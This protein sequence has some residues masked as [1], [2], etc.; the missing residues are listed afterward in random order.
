MLIQDFLQEHV[1]VNK[2][3]C[4]NRITGKIISACVPMHT[5]G[6]PLRIKEIKKV[7]DEYRIAVVEDA[8]ESLGSTYKRKS[9]GTFGSLGILSFNGNKI[10]TCGGGGAILTDDQNLAKRAKHLSTTAKLSHPWEFVHD[11]IGYNYRMPNLNA[12]LACAQ[13]EQL[14]AILENKRRLK[15]LY[16]VFFAG[17]QGVKFVEETIEASSNYWLNTIVFDEPEQ[18]DAFLE[19]SNSRNVMTRPVWRLMNKLPMYK[20][21]IVSSLE[22]SEYLEQR[23]VNIPSSPLAK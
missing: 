19:F 14:P 7:C 11:D 13:L 16:S 17:E 1:T 18:K 8:A 15:D 3:V 9:T 21:C 20:D 22:N 6:F 10:I 4:V 5:F 2:D 12:A 23:A